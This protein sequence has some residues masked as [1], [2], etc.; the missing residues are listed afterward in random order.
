[1]TAHGFTT[2][3]VH[4]GDEANDSRAVATPLYQTSAFR[5]G[6]ADEGAAMFSGA[7]PGDV[8]TRWS[9]P[10]ITE[11]EA[12][13]AALEGGEEG[14]AAASG[15]AAIAA[16]MMTC[17]EAGD[18][19]VVDSACYSAT[20]TLFAAELPRY[21]VSATFVDTNDLEAVD[22]S[23]TPRTRLIYTETPGNPTLKIVDL[24]RLAAF[25]RSR[26]LTTVCDNTFA[27]PVVQRP[28]ELGIDVSLHSATKYLGGHGDAI[29][30]VAAGPA[31]LMGRAK[32]TILRDFGGVI[33][34]MTAFLIARG[35]AT[36]ELRVRRQCDNALAV[37]RFLSEHPAVERVA[38]PGLPSH[39]GHATAARQMN[40]FGG[41]IAF[42]VKGG[43][44][45]GRTA[46]DAVRLCTL[47]VSLG[48]VRTLIC[49]PA[50]MTH[51]TVPAE[52]R[53]AAGIGDGL[54]RLSVGIEDPGDLI[55]DLDQALRRSMA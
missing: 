55:D 14:L 47:A 19:A 45:A 7:T 21:G 17:L 13:V 2:R 32:R 41:M 26:G 34:P 10:N 30:G 46:M 42:D 44:A 33:S 8:Y 1:M 36:V 39:P 54:I 37:A 28:L 38:Y 5:F 27:S 22:S 50:S 25:A 11:L 51:S 6:S 24:A 48:D 18:H 9:N 52:A 49:H 31:E 16:V 3:A 20:Y 4:A 35:I 12:K 43:V 53:R 15:M 40:G 29:A 23:V